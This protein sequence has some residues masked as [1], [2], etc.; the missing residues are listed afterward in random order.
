ML[1]GPAGVGKDALAL[2]FARLVNCT[3]PSDDGACGVCPTCRKTGV[4]QHPNVKFICALPL[5]KNEDARKDDPV[6]KLDNESLTAM[7]GELEAKWHDP[8][9]VIAIPRANEIKLSSVRDIRKELSMGSGGGTR[10]VIVS[11]AEMM[12]DESQNALLKTLEEPPKNTVFVLTTSNRDRLQSTV[13]SR[14]QPMRCDVLPEDAVTAALIKR[15]GMEPAL[16]ALCAEL[17]S[18]S[19]GL[20]RGYADEDFAA[21]RTKA[22]DFLRAIVVNNI[23]GL[24]AKLDELAHLRDKAV[25]EQ[26]LLILL[27]WFRDAEIMRLGGTPPTHIEGGDALRKFVDRFPGAR[28]DRAVQLIEV[29]AQDVRRNANVFLAMRVLATGLRNAVVS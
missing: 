7:R 17:G 13:R 5:G 23:A 25:I 16:A 10:V 2:E 27:F 12:S 29:A 20:A 19:Y 26:F 18:G 15:D 6:A 11:R 1:Y 3:E 8:Y 4:M 14:C 9:H 28:C 22:V 24:Y 21:A